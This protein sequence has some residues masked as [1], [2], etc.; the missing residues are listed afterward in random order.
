MRAVVDT[1]VLISALISD[2]SYPYRV[3][4]LWLNR[5]FE[6]VTS[7]WQLDELRG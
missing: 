2:K 4:E 6:L 1:G 5:A 3:L 7:D